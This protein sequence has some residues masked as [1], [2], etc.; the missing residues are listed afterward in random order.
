MPLTYT[1]PKTVQPAKA[2]TEVH[3]AGV[4]VRTPKDGEATVTFYFEVYDG[5]TKVHSQ[6]VTVKA[7]D[8]ISGYSEG[9]A[10]HANLKKI[11]YEEA[12]KLFGAGGTVS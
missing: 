8:L 5:A 12:R 1:T 3:C 11:A 4:N 2:G 10:T 6:S 9:P 7:A